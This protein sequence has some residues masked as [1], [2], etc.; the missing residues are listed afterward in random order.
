MTRTPIPLT[1]ADLSSFARHLGA[2]IKE[3]G[4]PSHLE[5]LN[6]LARAAGLRNYQHLRAISAA[7]L[8][9]GA[10]APP[11]VDHAQVERALRHFDG[12]GGLAQWPSRR[13]VQMLCLW[14]LWAGLPPGESL[15]ER[16]VSAL[17]NGLHGFGDAALLRRELIGMGVV[18]RSPGGLDYLRREVAPPAEARELIRRVAARRK[19]GALR[20]GKT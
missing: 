4:A 15:G 11:Q 20:V 1:V 9:L 5:L 19:S 16:Q 18:T 6:M 3:R 12:G 10:E 2:G 8:R 7:E 14:A 13:Q 17:L